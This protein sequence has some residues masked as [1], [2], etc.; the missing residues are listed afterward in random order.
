MVEFVYNTKNSQ[1]DK[2]PFVN[3][4]RIVVMYDALLL[5]AKS[6]CLMCA[7]GNENYVYRDGR[8][9]NLRCIHIVRVYARIE[10]QKS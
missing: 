7:H 3:L 10:T 1:F 2:S 9:R 5:N 4:A 6:K 8:R